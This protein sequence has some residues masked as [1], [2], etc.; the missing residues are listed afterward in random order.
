VGVLLCTESP[1]CA[2]AQPVFNANA[3]AVGLKLVAD[4]LASATQASYTAE[5]LTFKNG[6]ADAV[7]AFVNLN[8]FVRD[9]SRQNYNP[10]TI[11]SNLGPT[12]NTIKASPELLAGTISG[13]SEAWP[14]LD[15]TAPGAAALYTA[16]KAYKPDWV[17]TGKNAALFASDICVS[18]AG[19]LEFKKA[20]ENSGVT[21]SATVTSEDVIKGLSMFK[22]E[23]LGGV[24]PNVTFNDGSKANPQNLC[25]F[26]YKWVKGTFSAIPGPDGIYT[27]KP[28]G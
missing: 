11:N 2:Q 17:G 26:L 19:G 4:N 28:A 24:S 16:L 15:Q 9:C 21:A 12:L 1:A 6:G 5:C 22:N 8:V 3:T 25:V 14:C 20:I 7:A 27:C 10:I 13:S 18:W 23:T